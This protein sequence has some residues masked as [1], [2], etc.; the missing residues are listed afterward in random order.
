MINYSDR[1]TLKGMTGTFP[2][3]VEAG[4]KD[5]DGTDGPKAENNI[6]ENAPTDGGAAGGSVPYTQQDGPTKYAPMQRQPGTKIT[7]KSP[8]MQYPTS[9]V[10]IA[11]TFLPT[12]KQV[13]TMT[14]SGTYSV[15]SMENTVRCQ[16]YPDEN[17][18]QTDH[19]EGFPGPHAHGRHA[20]IPC[21][22]ERLG[23]AIL[24]HLISISA[25]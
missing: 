5:I 24:S 4:I 8:S 14:A 12:P 23:G 2:A 6:N 25:G 18:V 21:T 10:N 1:F 17:Q 22:M 15:S 13:T 19:L 16:N 20:K 9:S 7:A 11:K 3:A